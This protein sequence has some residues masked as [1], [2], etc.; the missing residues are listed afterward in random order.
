[1]DK[2][3]KIIIGV[4]IGIVV[5]LGLFGIVAIV[6]K[7]KKE[8]ES[9]DEVASTIPQSSSIESTSATIKG[10][11]FAIND[12]VAPSGTSVNVRK[13]A[14]TSSDIITN[15]KSGSVI[16]KVMEK[17]TVSGYYW[18]KV[19]LINGTIG[20]VRGDIIKKTTY[21]PLKSTRTYNVGEILNPLYN[22]VV[23]YSE[24]NQNSYK[25]ISNLYTNQI[26]YKSKN[27][28]WFNVDL[29]I[30]VTNYVNNQKFTSG[31]VKA[32]SVF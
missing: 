6:R 31:Y 2:N 17:I 19:S 27:G 22:N 1:M 21:T 24:P 32:E 9:E 16:G 4:S 3:K 10:R 29:I 26:K 14:S 18:Y 20:Y 11:V 25:I 13:T 5:I 23:V 28:D 12:Y 7:S 30:P 15:V 8:N